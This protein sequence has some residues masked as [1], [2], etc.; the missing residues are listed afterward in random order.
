MS[1]LSTAS[2]ISFDGP[3]ARTILD[4]DPTT[5]GSF[6]LYSN[7]T[8]ATMATKSPTP[9]A[10]IHT[11]LSPANGEGSSAPAIKRVGGKANVSSACGPCKRAHLA[12]DVARPCKRC[13]NMGKQDQCEDVPHKKRGRPKVAKP[14]MGEPYQRRALGSDGSDLS[15]NA[16]W[17]GPS[18]YDAPYMS[19]A[20]PPPPMIS[21]PIAPPPRASPPKPAASALEESISPA[22]IFTVFTTTELKILRASPACYQLT[23]YHP[24]EFVNLNLLDWLHPADRHLIDMERNRLINVPF[25]AGPLQSDRETQA[26][27]TQRSERELLSPAEGMREP[28][29]NQNV[30]V[31]RSDNLFNLFNVRLHLG[32]GLG[33]SLWRSETLSRI[34]LVIS[35]LL[36]PPQSMP[37]DMQTDGSSRRSNIGAPSMPLIPPTP[38]TPAPHVVGGVAN[39]APIPTAPSSASGGGGLPSFSAIAAAAD[40]PAPIATQLPPS[41][42]RYDSVP[43][44]AYY[45]TPTTAS[46]APPPRAPQAVHHPQAY[47]YQQQPRQAGYPRRST[48]PGRNHAHAHPQGYADYS[49]PAM[50]STAGYYDGRQGGEDDWRRQQQQQQQAVQQ[51]DYTKRS[52]EL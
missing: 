47:A 39:S 35:C 19:T 40:A 45:A 24:H 50:A 26:A 2:S 27:I 11:P 31:L 9:A 48:S 44:S 23:G 20:E 51:V 10:S 4:N 46:A 49:Q 36:I 18:A 12:C 5:S 43:S 8:F 38:I 22:N 52:W 41:V 15:A 21:L 14:A 37:R 42:P 30:R 17:R 34:Y 33:G 7:T 25:V 6:P 3:G 16:K 13:V 28:Y 1:R 29:P 32:G